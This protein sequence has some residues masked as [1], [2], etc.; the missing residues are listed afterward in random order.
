MDDPNVYIAW[1]LLEV[2]LVSKLPNHVWV[3][4]TSKLD[5]IMKRGYL[6][7]SCPP[8]GLGIKDEN[9]WQNIDH[10]KVGQMPQPQMPL[11]T[12]K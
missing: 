8:I 10:S 4:V 6:T 2:N 12:D 5:P 1:I 7:D 9:W 11:Y 3:K